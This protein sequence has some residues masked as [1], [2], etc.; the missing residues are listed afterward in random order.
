MAYK[1]LYRQFRPRRFG[2][3]K[4]Q[5]AI[6]EVLKNQVKTG[7][8]SH[9][10]VFAG[11]RGT[12]KTSTA[13]ILASALNCLAP[14]EGEPC[15]RCEN[16][17]AALSD[18]MPDIIEMD[19]ASN[20]SVDDARD[21]RDKINLLPVKGKYK[22]YI[23]DEVHMLSNSAFNALL[24]TLEEPPEYGVFILATTELRK[25]P[26]TVL[27]RCQRFDFKSVEDLD[28]KQRL[29]EVLA[30]IGGEAEEE[31]LA[32]IAQA[33]QGGL[34]DAL[35][36]LD[37]CCAVGG[38]VTCG[39]VAEV[40]NLAD[41]GMIAALAKAI[42][43]YDERGA[44]TDLDRMMDGG[45]DPATIVGQLLLFFRELLVNLVMQEGALFALA[46]TTSRRA[47]LRALEVLSETENRMSLSQN[48]SIILEA[49]VIRLLL[50]EQEKAEDVSLRIEKL[51]KKL[52]QAVLAPKSAEPRAQHEAV[53]RKLPAVKKKPPKRTVEDSD[54]WEK[55]CQLVHEKD[56][57]L[58]G[59]IR[60]LQLVGRENG[61]L[62]VT[63]EQPSHVRLFDTGTAKAELEAFAAELAGEKLMIELV[64]G[65]ELQPGEMP[66]DAE[67]ID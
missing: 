1:A 46:K 63:G 40:L 41:A 8:P 66:E 34:R 32:M 55:L 56:I 6:A 19:A 21:L 7:R 20:T 31:A 44:L 16:C 39:V 67:I 50:P 64:N 58:F 61:K 65:D 15:L 35:T 22:V 30:E 2:E 54:F 53:A 57:G 5:G 3:L 25:L 38:K 26:K 60:H 4:G 14:E 10:Y 23:I 37:K 48:P 59:K 18:S 52:A 24:K 27:S 43:E 9:A 11:P 51:E 17:L 36:I 42:L 29:R 28:I 13:K 33:A 62:I 45:I 47:V 49:A 12:G